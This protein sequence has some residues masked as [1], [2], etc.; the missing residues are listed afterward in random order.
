MDLSK[1]IAGTVQV[2]KQASGHMKENLRSNQLS[3][4]L[5][6]SL[7]IVCAESIWAVKDQF[8]NLFTTNFRMN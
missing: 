7:C 5:I 8:E 2:M 3:F 4:F 6:S 1:K